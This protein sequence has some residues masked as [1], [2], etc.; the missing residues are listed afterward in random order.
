MKTLIVGCSFVNN[1][2][3]D[4]YTNKI[5]WI[6]HPDVYTSAAPGAGNESIAVRLLHECSQKKYDQVFVL[7]SGINRI[8]VSLSEKLKPHL[9]QCSFCVDVGGTTWYHSGGMAGSWTDNTYTYPGIVKELIKNQYLEAD[10]RYL[11]D[12]TFRSIITAQSFLSQQNISYKM[13]F[14]Y[15]IYKDY[16]WQESFF[17]AVDVTS[18]MFKLIDWDKIQTENTLYEWA[19]S[20][21]TRMSDRIHPSR[22]A[23]REWILSNVDLDIAM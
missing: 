21:P 18:P 11:S 9:D 17:G 12:R 10:I 13:A 19:S 8:D 15:D 4:H 23:V 2:I 22:D 3:W 1:L 7:W 16:S 20:D 5:N 14:A 6:L